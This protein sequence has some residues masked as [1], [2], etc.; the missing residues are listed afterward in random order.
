MFETACSLGISVD[1]KAYTN[2]IVYYGKAGNSFLLTWILNLF[3]V[4]FVTIEA[5]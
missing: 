5:A 3:T 4:I 1:E 2:M